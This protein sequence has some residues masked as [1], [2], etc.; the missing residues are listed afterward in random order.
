VLVCSA[1]ESLLMCTY[2][3]AESIGGCLARCEA[4]CFTLVCVYTQLFNYGDDDAVSVKI[5]EDRSKAVMKF[6]RDVN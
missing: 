6:C 1:E 4:A 5:C 3:A 2:G